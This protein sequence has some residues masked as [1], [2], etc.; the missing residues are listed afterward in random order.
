MRTAKKIIIDILKEEAEMG[1]SYEFIANRIINE[2]R[3]ERTVIMLPVDYKK[4]NNYKSAEYDKKARK[5][6]RQNDELYK[7]I[8]KSIGEETMSTRVYGI[9]RRN[10]YDSIED[11]LTLDGN[12]E[13]IL[14]MRNCGK[15]TAGT[16]K[17]VIDDLKQDSQN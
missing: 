6:R 7:A 15:L 10:N 12:D 3:L 8:H 2:L 5:E 1:N 16:I 11:L 9:L 13:R 4:H 17:K 14:R